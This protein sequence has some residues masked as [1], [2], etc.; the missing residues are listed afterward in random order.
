MN[1]R[2]KTMLYGIRALI[3]LAQAAPDSLSTDERAARGSLL[4][5]AE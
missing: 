5:A 4:G 2:S 1:M 3:A